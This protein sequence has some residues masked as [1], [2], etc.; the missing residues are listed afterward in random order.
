[1]IVAAVISGPCASGI[2]SFST[3]SASWRSTDCRFRLAKA[4]TRISSP[5]SSRL[6]VEIRLAMY[7]SASG[8]ALSRS[9]TAFFRKM[10]MRVF[11]SEGG[12]P[13][14]CAF[15]L[16]DVGGNPA[17]DVLKCLGRR[18]EPVLDGLLPQ[19]GDA[20]LQLRRL[21]VG[22][23]A[24]FEPAA[25]PVLEGH[26]P[27]GRPVARDDD[28]LAGV[29]QRIK[30]VEELLLGSLLVLQELDV[31]H[32]QHVDVPGPAPEAVLLAVPDHVDEVV[33]ELLR[34]HVAHLDALIEALGV[35]ADGM[36]QVR[37]AQAG[38]PVN[39]QRFIGLGGASATATA[40]AW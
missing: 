7:S 23:Q 11:R 32:Q 26:Q 18:V 40:A 2:R 38:V 3:N 27:L 12:D 15:E 37:L 22:E 9:W 10:A 36:Q 17:R 34:A 24:P 33:G 28:L 5:S 20:G 16:T 21:D 8:G 31:V 25:Q 1:M 13:D 19:D 39:K 35:V 6:L 30:G 14:Q 4:V 29:V